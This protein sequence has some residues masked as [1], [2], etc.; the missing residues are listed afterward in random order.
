MCGTPLANGGSSE[1]RHD[2]TDSYFNRTIVARAFDAKEALQDHMN[3]R[4]SGGS[5]S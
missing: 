4:C 3:R 1:F 5:F 2:K